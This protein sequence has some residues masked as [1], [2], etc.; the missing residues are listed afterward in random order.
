MVIVGE[1]NAGKRFRPSDWTER[2]C[3]CLSAF[4]PNQRVTYSPYLKPMLIND[5]KCVVVDRELE[6]IDPIAFK[7]L[8]SFAKDNDLKV[9]DRPRKRG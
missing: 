5:N 1:T 9:Q 4:E 8:L 2:L 6:Q 7:F 3:G